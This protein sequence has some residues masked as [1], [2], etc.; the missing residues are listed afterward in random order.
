MSSEKQFVPFLANPKGFERLC[1]DGGETCHPSVHHKHHLIWKFASSKVKSLAVIPELTV[2][3]HRQTC[4]SSCSPVWLR[5]EVP[6]DVPPSAIIKTEATCSS[7]HLGSKGQSSSSSRKHGGHLWL[8][9]QLLW[10]CL[11]WSGERYC[12]PD[13]EEDIFRL[14]L[15]VRSH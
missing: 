14:W 13:W 12:S 11:D 10:V 3:T 7:C 5:M 1:L 6:S 9:R 4:G 8:T 15:K 2:W